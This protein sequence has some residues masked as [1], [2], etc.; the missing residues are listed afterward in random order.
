MILAEKT[1]PSAFVV[2]AA[3][4]GTNTL[5]SLLKQH[6]D[7][8]V[9]PER[10]SFDYFS[11]DL[12]YPLRIKRESEYLALFSKEIKEVVK[13]EVSSSYLASKVAAH[14][15]VEKIPAAKII[16]SL[17]N[18]I[19]ATYAAHNQMVYEGWENL[20]DFVEALA[21]EKE[22]ATGHT[23]VPK[24]GV[25]TNIYL[26]T[27]IFGNYDL[28][29]KRYREV[30]GREQV[31][32]FLFDDLVADP[33]AVAAQMYDF[34]EVDTRFVPQVGI[35]N[36]SKY[37]KNSI[38]LRSLQQLPPSVEHMIRRSLPPR[39]LDKILFYLKKVTTTY[40][41]R[42]PMPIDIQ[43]RLKEQYAPMVERLSR[44]LDRDLS[45]WLL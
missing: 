37:V 34:L 25:A 5:H 3:K 18:P 23:P 11:P 38:L 20:T 42:P 9:P 17:R 36:P 6:P 12:D 28:Q 32:I 29:V 19:E 31:L 15:I 30:F 14:K 4:A 40:K 21:A 16:I 45:G 26:Y 41:P 27:N 22:R 2:G 10:V 35:H 44:M 7:V 1:W 43:S 8:F 39:I 24:P 13:A 33:L